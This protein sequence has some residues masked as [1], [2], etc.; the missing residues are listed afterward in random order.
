MSN[1]GEGACTA[2]PEAPS[3]SGSALQQLKAC[4]HTSDV[5]WILTPPLFALS[6]LSRS[7]QVHCRYELVFLCQG[8][9]PREAAHEK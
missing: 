1:T 5:L 6:V 4:L 3:Q 9:S 7:K 2:R 8:L